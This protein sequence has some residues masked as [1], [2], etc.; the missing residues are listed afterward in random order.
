MSEPKKASAAMEK[1][2]GED[3]G[4]NKRTFRDLNIQNYRH[5]FTNLV[6]INI[7]FN[8]KTKEGQNKEGEIRFSFPFAA[9]PSDNINP[10]KT[11]FS[12]FENENRHI[13]NGKQ[14]K[15]I[16]ENAVKTIKLKRD[17]ERITKDLL[18]QQALDQKI[19]EL[20]REAELKLQEKMQELQQQGGGYRKTKNTK[21]KNTKSKTKNKNTKNKKFK[22]KNTKNTKSKNKNTKNKKFKTKNTKKKTKNYNF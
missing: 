14:F 4:A 15:N 19:E 1:S 6:N 12:E 5:D 17:Q 20:E 7:S 13:F 16:Y 11:A 9:Q 18:I 8:Y 2:T 3:Q 21:S 22:N 10:L